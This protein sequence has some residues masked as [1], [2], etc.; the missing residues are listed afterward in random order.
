MSQ[1]GEALLWNVVLASGIAVAAALTA[2]A[3]K[4]PALA[5]ALWLLVLLKLVTP[6]LV[7]WPVLPAERAELVGAVEAEPIPVPVAEL[8]LPGPPPEV[9]P[10]LPAE[11]EA[12]APASEASKAPLLPAVWLTG[13]LLL[14]GLALTRVWRF[15]RVVA[16]A[17]RPPREVEAEVGRLAARVG[18]R[19]PPAVR[20]V[21]G[22][23]PPLALPG[24]RGARILLPASLLRRLS[25][26]ERETVLLHEL[27]HIGR[28]DHLI[29]WL[30]F[31]IV[32]IWWWLPVA[33]WAR[34]GLR[35]AEERCCDAWVA[36]ASPGSAGPYG[37]ALMKTLDFLSGAR[38]APVAVASGLGAP[39]RLERRFRMIIEG[40]PTFRRL[41]APGRLALLVVALAVLPGTVG[42]A[43]AGDPE[44]E[45]RP[46]PTAGPGED[47]FEQRLS[48]LEKLTETLVEE[49]RALRTDRHKKIWT[50]IPYRDLAAKYY[51]AKA[52]QGAVRTTTFT[53]K[54]SDGRTYL[55]RTDDDRVTCKDSESGEVLWTAALGEPVYPQPALEEG[56]VVFTSSKTPGRR[57]SVH[58]ETGRLIEVRDGPPGATGAAA[59]RYQISL[60]RA[61]LDRERT[62]FAG[63][64]AEIQVQMD[65]LRRQEVELQAAHQQQEADT[66]TA[67]EALEDRLEKLAAEEGEK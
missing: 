7:S 48:R 4:R 34:R 67:I 43:V 28:R 39:G 66:L 13:T 42:V 23:I 57:F 45:D 53:C 58:P 1:L 8:A 17:A 25:P 47:E 29:R 5:H 49:L 52:L 50:W 61:R 19:R 24:L 60:M 2:R 11:V 33:W 9:F 65:V 51:T 55:I 37:R 36:W 14:L 27:A 30:E 38:P 40:R 59:V 64:L 26:R 18:L 31:G 62:Q 54:A 3:T 35:E 10:V 21:P 46:A 20:L 12:P 32:S 15:S 44:P 56:R 6:P 22:R 63:K 16:G 41:S